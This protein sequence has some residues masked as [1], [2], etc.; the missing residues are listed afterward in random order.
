MLTTL[1][2]RM[3]REAML[4]PR[5][6]A[7]RITIRTLAEGVNHSYEHIRK[8]VIGEPVVSEALNRAICEYLGLDEERMWRLAVRDKTTR[9]FGSAADR[10]L[11]H[12]KDPRFVDL[13][14]KLADGD[15]RI[16]LTLAETMV[17]A[18]EARARR[19]GPQPPAPRRKR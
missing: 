4:R 2:G 13:W 12:P 7:P 5:K 6:G 14:E 1:Y 15:K 16:L 8:V 10:E 19:L 18:A 17:L 3:V 11:E 9:R